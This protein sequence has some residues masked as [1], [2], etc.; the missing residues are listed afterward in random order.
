MVFLPKPFSVSPEVEKPLPL[1]TLLRASTGPLLLFLTI[2]RSRLSFTV[3]LR[4]SFLK[5]P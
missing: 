2:K 5:M 1:P 4:N 3:S